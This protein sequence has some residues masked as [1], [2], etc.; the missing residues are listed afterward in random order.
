MTEYH[1]ETSYS[2]PDGI[3]LNLDKKANAI[4]DK[5]HAERVGSGCWL[6]D[7]GP[8]DIEYVVKNKKTAE[9]LALALQKAGF[10][11][12]YFTTDDLGTAG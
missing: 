12:S 2:H 5:F 7:N 6:S 3:N 1:V 11:A 4:A 8:R 9:S 10:S